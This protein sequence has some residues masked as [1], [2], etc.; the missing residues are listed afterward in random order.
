MF[1]FGEVTRDSV[2]V[3]EINNNIQVNTFSIFRVIPELRYQFV[4][5]FKYCDLCNNS[6]S[7]QLLLKQVP[8]TAVM[9][10]N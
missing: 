4:S 2:K 9:I 3:I 8:C 7:H 6:T 10:T 1:F 5:L